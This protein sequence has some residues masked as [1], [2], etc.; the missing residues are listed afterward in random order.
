MDNEYLPDYLLIEE[1][2]NEDV[3]NK[4]EEETIRKVIPM[5]LN[6]FEEFYDIWFIA[7]MIKTQYMLKTDVDD[8]RQ[9][10]SGYNEIRN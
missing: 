2:V 3:E 9:M 1:E 10:I 6:L 7:Q 5:F 8:I 4:D